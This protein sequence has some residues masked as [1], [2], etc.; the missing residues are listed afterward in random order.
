MWGGVGRVGG[1]GAVRFGSDV[2]LET[3]FIGQST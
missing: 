3:S 1:A 2:G